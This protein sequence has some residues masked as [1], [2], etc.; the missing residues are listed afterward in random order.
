MGVTV[1]PVGNQ[2]NLELTTQPLPTEKI[3]A[4]RGVTR[5]VPE[6]IISSGQVIV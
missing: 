1:N 5:A 6:V 4:N 3:A 2:L